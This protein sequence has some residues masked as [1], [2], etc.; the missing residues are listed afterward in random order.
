MANVYILYSEK[1]ALFYTGSCAEFDFRHELHLSK[2]F[3]GSFTVRADD[4]VLFFRIDDLGYRQARKI[5]SHIKRMNSS[6]YIK[7]LAKYPDMVDKLK[8]KY[9]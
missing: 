9:K 5:E 2:H 3:P 4:W 8:L 6:V 7:N 1:I